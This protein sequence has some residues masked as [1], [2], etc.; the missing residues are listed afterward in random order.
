M[1]QLK[2]CRG[3]SS[4]QTYST[5]AVSCNGEGQPFDP[6][7]VLAKVEVDKVDIIMS[8]GWVAEMRSLSSFL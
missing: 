8:A 4:S 1:S 3:S 5:R 2:S 6:L 7:D